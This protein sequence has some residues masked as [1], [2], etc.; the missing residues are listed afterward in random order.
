MTSATNGHAMPKLTPLAPDLPRLRKLLADNLPWTPHDYIPGI[1][2]KGDRDLWAEQLTG[3][4]LP[5]IDL[6]F[7]CTLSDGTSVGLFAEY[8]PWDSEFF[9]YGIARLNGIWPLAPP[10]LEPALNYGPA[11]AALLH[12]AVHRDVRYLF[13]QVDPRDLPLLRALGE[14]GFALIET[15]YYQH[16]P[17]IVP[18]M[19]E[20]YPVRLAREEDIASLARAASQT[21]NL[22]D[23]FHADPFIRPEDAA[24]LMERWVEQSVRGKL[25]DVTIVPDVVD[26]GAFVTYR[27]HREKW[28]R[29]GVNLVQGVLS[30]VSPEFMGWMGK[31]AP[32]V[33]LHL[34]SMGA[35]YSFGSTQVTNRPIIWFAQE[36]GA[37]FGKC[38]HV[39]RI[40]L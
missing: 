8:L 21:V 15:R 17:V 31:L 14:L 16:G 11:L 36:A 38:E 7:G 19:P 13:A 18:Q 5:E 3:P 25:A 29:W 4:L 35:E 33:N 9:G 6:R 32:E 26:P 34:R 22:Y 23:R 40:V 24:R 39:L 2:R 37:R 12:R 10:R 20:R 30:A 28:S 1:S 27:Y